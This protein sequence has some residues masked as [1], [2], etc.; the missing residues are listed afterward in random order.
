MSIYFFQVWKDP[1]L[2]QWAWSL[3]HSHLRSDL[4]GLS[5]KDSPEKGI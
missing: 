5:S 4:W 3:V 2:D 1:D